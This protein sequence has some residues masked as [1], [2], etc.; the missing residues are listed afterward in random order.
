MF[1]TK[2]IDPKYVREIGQVF[3][4]I[5]PAVVANEPN[6]VIDGYRATI[7]PFEANSVGFSN[8]TSFETALFLD[9]YNRAERHNTV[10]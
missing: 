8:F 10:R 3:F 4:I 2:I 6:I 5:I 1:N 7:S 9:K